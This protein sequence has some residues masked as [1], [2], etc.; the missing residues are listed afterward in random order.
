MKF[1]YILIYV[2]HNKDTK[3]KDIIFETKVIYLQS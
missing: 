1:V 3:T 2:Y